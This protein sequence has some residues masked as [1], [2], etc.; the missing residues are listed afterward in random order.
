MGLRENRKN[1]LS[2]STERANLISEYKTST[3]VE[4]IHILLILQQLNLKRAFGLKHFKSKR[5]VAFSCLLV[6]LM[7]GTIGAR[8][9]VCCLGFDGNMKFEE[10]AFGGSCWKKAISG[11]PDADLSAS[12]QAGSVHTEPCCKCTDI[13]ISM[14]GLRVSRVSQDNSLK[15]IVLTSISWDYVTVSPSAEDLNL[16]S[17]HKTHLTKINPI[18]LSLKSTILLI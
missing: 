3:C 8:N 7:L 4:D 9:M 16:S 15:S 18:L 1:N 11:L 17:F 2:I 14:V 12:D 6:Y 5:F 10:S 13:S